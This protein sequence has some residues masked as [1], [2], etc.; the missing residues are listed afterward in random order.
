MSD[1][2]Q[3]FEQAPTVQLHHAGRRT[4]RVGL[5]S[6]VLVVVVALAGTMLRAMPA[7]SVSEAVGTEAPDFTL[8]L[9]DGAEMRLSS[10]RGQPVVL[11]FWA[12][13]CVPCKEEAPAL[14]AGWRRWKDKGVTFMGVAARDSKRWARKFMKDYGQGYQ[15]FFDA[16]AVVMTRYGARGFPETFFIDAEGVI[17]S[18]WIGPIKGDALD[19]EIQKMLPAPKPAG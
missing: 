9:L 14:A 8:P 16:G 15:S 17:R 6:L 18:K 4:L 12:S 11:N 2:A 10:L 13:W 7:K 5:A 19:G 3:V 1:A